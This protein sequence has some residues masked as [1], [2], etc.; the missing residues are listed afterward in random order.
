M[1]L[2]LI[3]L[4]GGGLA[5]LAPAA[6]AAVL[7]MVPMQ[8]SMVMPMVAYHADHGHLHVM[9]PSEVPQ[10]TPLLVSHPGDQ[11]DPA[12]PWFDD[13]DPTRKGLSFS[14]RYGFV[15]DAMSDPLPP[16]TAIWLAK[17]SGPADLGFFR[18]S[19]NAPKNWEP[20]FGT[21]GS[22]AALEWNGMM[23]HPAV[24]APPGTNTYTAV[25]EAYLV[26]NTT[27]E[28]L[29]HSE[30]GPFEFHFTNVP[31]GRPALTIARKVEISWSAASAGWLLE[32]ASSL[33]AAEWIPVG[34]PPILIEGRPAVLLEPAA[35][36]RYFRLRPPQ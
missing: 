36:T 22:P 32:D 18:Y 21:A 30:S 11:F 12:D 9:M 23:F 17:R 6:A 14:R 7:S 2:K 3:S 19:G 31:D 5:V 35:A 28:P 25:F 34:T 29:H 10:L 26:D 27:G 13:L 8:G 4:V 33:P 1:K 16:N 24:T 20:I 15:M